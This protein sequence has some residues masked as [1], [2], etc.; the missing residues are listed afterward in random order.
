MAQATNEISRIADIKIRA[1]PSEGQYLNTTHIARDVA[2]LF[3]ADIEGSLRGRISPDVR[4]ETLHSLIRD[5][6][7]RRLATMLIPDVEG[8]AE[9]VS[10]ALPVA[11]LKPSEV[12]EQKLVTLS[13]A[14][15]YRSVEAGRFYC[16]RPRGQTNGRVFPAWQFVGAVPELLPKVLDSFRGAL[17]TEVHAFF[18]TARDELNELA[19]A[20]LLA[21]KLFE[22]RG[23]PHASQRR[24]LNLPTVERQ[25]R[26]ID[27]IPRFGESVAY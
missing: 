13:I 17:E 23:A 15:L 16:V 3:A 27:A 9:A 20:E 4:A 12:V 18:V 25:R 8:A 10:D 11:N 1:V 5:T 21:G 26:V 7:E 6:L 22:G 14:S 2:E 24:L 19:P